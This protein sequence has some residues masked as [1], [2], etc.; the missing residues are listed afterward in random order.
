MPQRFDK[1]KQHITLKTCLK[2]DLTSQ[3]TMIKKTATPLATCLL[4]A[5]IWASCS[6]TEQPKTEFIKD[7]FP[8]EV[9]QYT[10]YKLDSTVYV[11][12]NTEKV[13]H[14]YLLQEIVDAKITDNLGREGYRIRRMIRNEQDTTIWDDAS[15]YIIVPA[16]HTL[17]VINDNLRFIKLHEPIKDDYTW[18]GNSFLNTYSD[19]N[20]LYLKDWDYTYANVKQPLTVGNGIAFSETVTVNEVADTLGIPGNKDFLWEINYS[21][22][23]YAKGKGLVFR[24]FHHE[25]WQPPNITCGA[26]C[27]ETNSYGVRLRYLNSNR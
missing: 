7:Y 21:Q 20:L 16:D 9:G 13:V 10:T 8:L 14:S 26:G 15:S 1:A 24:E 19:P 11:T 3:N 25:T 2:A 18:R 6:K 5:I 27:F 23:V 4:L 17:E 22:D 12:L